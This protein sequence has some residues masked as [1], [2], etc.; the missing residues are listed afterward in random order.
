MLSINKI[1]VDVHVAIF[2]WSETNNARMLGMS[3]DI[4][5]HCG[6]SVGLSHGEM[7]HG[8]LEQGGL[9]RSEL[10]LELLKLLGGLL[11]SI[12]WIDVLVI[13]SKVN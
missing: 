10:G 8:I 13:I 1:V 3:C 11:T 9:E 12:H 5:S 2:G 7:I 4:G 6:E